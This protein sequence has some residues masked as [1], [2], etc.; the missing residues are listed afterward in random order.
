VR[1]LT[2]DDDEMFRYVI[3]ANLATPEF[4][5]SEAATATEGLAKMSEI[6]PDVV[7]LDFEFPDMTGDAVVERLAAN[8]ATAHVPIIVITSHYDAVREGHRLERATRVIS[9]AALSSD[10]LRSAIRDAVQVS[11]AQ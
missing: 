2:I 1:V 8:P 7:L 3:R 10:V 6:R 11:S 5:V 4:Q 9:K